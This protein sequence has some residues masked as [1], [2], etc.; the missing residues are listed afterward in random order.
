MKSLFL[1]VLN[2]SL[3]AGWPVLAEQLLQLQHTSGAADQQWMDK[4]YRTMRT[5]P[6]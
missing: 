1:T 6:E 4:Y 3:T 2:M 5:F